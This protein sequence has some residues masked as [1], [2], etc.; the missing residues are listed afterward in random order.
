MEHHILITDAVD[1]LLVD[2][3]SSW[4]TVRYQ[5][6]ISYEKTM[7][8]VHAFDGLIVNSKIRVD[9]AFLD[10]APR[11]Q[12]VGRLGSGMDIFDLE[13]ARI[14][15]INIINT[16]E[17]NANAVGEHALA[18][19][20]S[21]YNRIVPADEMVRSMHTWDRE[22]L[23][24]R[25]VDGCTIGII[26]CG[27]TGSAFVRKLRGFDARVLIYDKYAT[28]SSDL[29]PR[30]EIVDLDSVMRQAEI[31]SL[32]LPLTPETSGWINESFLSMC[33]QLHTVINTSRGRILPLSAVVTWLEVD[34]RR[35]ACLD[36]FENEKPD[37]YTKD[38]KRWMTELAKN[39]NVVLTPH[40]AGWTMESR[41]KIALAM[42]EKIKRVSRIN[43]T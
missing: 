22:S 6:Y 43:E 4:A 11:L 12:W 2:E 14:R 37:T 20:L 35:G 39:D 15:G 34:P 25:E 28:P 10:S 38:Q 41:R 5:P 9:S 42:L 7:D 1:E 8:I 18:S 23:R 24:G 29:H 16:P 31:L 36:V 21:L 13:E 3:L 27:H 19:L 40:V 32:H 17:G 33:P 30:Q 26:G